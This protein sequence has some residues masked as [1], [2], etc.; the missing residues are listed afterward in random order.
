MLRLIDALGIAERSVLALVG[1][2]GKTSAA[3]TLARECESAIVTTTTHLGA[4]QPGLADAH[5]VL[6]RAAAAPDMVSGSDARVLAVTGP[7]DSSTGRWS[8]LDAAAFGWLRERVSRTNRL[9]I[10]EAD[11]SRLRPLKAPAAHEPAIPGG[12]DRVVVTAGL[13][14]LGA[15]LTELYVHRPERFSALSRL[16]HGARVREEDLVR[17]LVHAEGGLKGIPSGAAPVVLL[18]HADGERRNR[19]AAM[20]PDLLRVFTNV[21]LAAS[22]AD[23]TPGTGIGQ[24]RLVALASHRRIA[25]VV[26]AGGGSTRFGRPKPLL[27]FHGQPFVRA[28]SRTALTA[29]LSPVVVVVGARGDD[30]ERAV[31][32]LS[33]TV[34]RNREW[35]SGQSSSVRA[36]IAALPA[37]TGAAIFLMADQPHVSLAV[38]DALI[39]SHALGLH[40]VIAPV[41]SGQRATPVLFDA[42]TFADLSCLS[43]DQGGRPVIQKRGYEPVPWT[44]DSLLLDV[45]TPEDYA[46]LCGLPAPHAGPRTRGNVG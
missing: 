17:V 7:F 11:G 44:D 46:R 20:I 2:G 27:D 34:V 3:F 1:A 22:A 43:G 25:G 30:V 5:A 15:P 12:V 32:G 18:T 29:G 10:V 6:S 33:V 26:L 23:V 37:R 35:T 45:D 21:T 14:G 24:D 41:V 16:A 39:H 38:L 4:G 8:G 42:E 19:T 28:V 31:D 40:P 9:L 36:G 13:N